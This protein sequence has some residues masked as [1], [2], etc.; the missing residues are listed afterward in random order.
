MNVLFV[1][2]YP[3]IDGS[4]TYKFRLAKKLREIGHHSFFLFTC[5]I[6]KE[7]KQEVEKNAPLFYVSDLTE[8]AN[9]LPEIDV[10]HAGV[11]GDMIP[12]VYDLKRKYF[13]QAAVVFGA[14]ASNA[15][16]HRSKIGFSPDGLFYKKFLKLLPDQ[17]ISFMGPTIKE[18]HELFI[19]E[20]ISGPIITNALR[21]PNTFEERN[22]T[23]P[24]KIVSIGRL[25][26]SKEYVFATI[27][28]VKA[29]RAE[30]MQYEFHV[31]GKGEYLPALQQRVKEEQLES[32]IFLHGEI[33]YS[34]VNDTLRAAGLFIGMG[35]AII[36]AAALGIPSLQAIEY[37]T[38]YTIYGWFHE[39]LDGEIG[40]FRKDKIT[41]PLEKVLK[42]VY[43]ISD[44]EYARLSLASF[45]RAQAFS[46]DN[47][48][49]TYVQF[50][51]NADREFALQIPSWQRF[52]LKVCRQPFKLIAQRPA[53]VIRQ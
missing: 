44:E 24:R 20:P 9:A 46:L 34:A 5:S 43:N 15:F 14:W 35:A 10:I 49:H 4:L 2:S 50:L 26:P 29:L 45:Q 51:Q 33:P 21:L 30:G 28:V 7:L 23:N 52:L 31:Y 11:D 16:I 53:E 19:N 47:V 3:L 41:Y 38:E 32:F 18:K 6:T 48:I 42:D 36:E 22:I 27:D 37:H 25:S 1:R 40:E 13:K 8:N 12:Y 39:L 17:N